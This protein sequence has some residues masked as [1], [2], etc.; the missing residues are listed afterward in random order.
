MRRTVRSANKFTHALEVVAKYEEMDAK[1]APSKSTTG[2]IE[3]SAEVTRRKTLPP[4]VAG[5][6]E[7]S[8]AP[9]EQSIGNLIRY[10]HEG[11]RFATLVSVGKSTAKVH[12]C[13]T[14]NH[15]VPIENVEA[16]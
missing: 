1:V 11:W 9:I 3:A 5:V 7:K 6:T 15:T 4:S 12:H 13:I 10:Y 16:I 14:G 8:T 2:A